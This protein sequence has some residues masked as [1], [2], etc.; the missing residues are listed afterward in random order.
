[1][2]KTRGFATITRAMISTDA[3]ALTV[4]CSWQACMNLGMIDLSLDSV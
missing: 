3:K 4:L 1:V 2:L